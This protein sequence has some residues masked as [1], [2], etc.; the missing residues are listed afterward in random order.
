MDT[1]TVQAIQ[2]FCSHT[3]KCRQ[4]TTPV[5][6]KIKQL[7]HAKRR[8]VKE[9]S[10]TYLN[11]APVYVVHNTTG[12]GVYKL[13]THKRNCM[14]A[15]NKDIVAHA[16]RSAMDL[17]R[18]QPECSVDAIIECISQAVH[19]QRSYSKHALNIIQ[20]KQTPSTGAHILSDTDENYAPITQLA[21]IVDDITVSKKQ[22]N[23]VYKHYNEQKQSHSNTILQFMKKNN[24]SRQNIELRG[25][26]GQTESCV[27]KA[28]TTHRMRTVGKTKMK[29]VISDTVHKIPHFME[30]LTNAHNIDMLAA[31]VLTHMK[32]ALSTKKDTLLIQP[33]K[34]KRSCQPQEGGGESNENGG[35]SGCSG[36]SA[37]GS[38]NIDGDDT[39]DKDSDTGDDDDVES[40]TDDAE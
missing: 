17:K 21:K 3:Q 25:D 30:Q 8:L 34:R 14:R 11:Q 22:V 7:G 40:D 18:Q 26:T 2:H 39:E 35:D 20:R 29:T 27:L 5:V 24:T 19:Q 4:E 16:I 36:E 10:D 37:G 23:L 1:D 9:L 32:D 13:Y 38:E 28:N 33:R 31:D 15:I 6:D 12:G